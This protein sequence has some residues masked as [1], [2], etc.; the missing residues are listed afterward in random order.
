M[1]DGCYS[2]L[3]YKFVCI[4]QEADLAVASLTINV[5]R[6]KVVDFT[7]PYIEL[8]TLILLY[9]EPE[10]GFSLTRFAEPFSFDLLVVFVCSWPIVGLVAWIAA[11]YS[12]YDRSA[13]KKEKKV[14]A[15]YGFSYSMWAQYGSLTLQGLIDYSI[16]L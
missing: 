10:K 15:L 9:K 6:I 13:L 14:D 5:D 8:G 1:H 3:I 12:P 4:L 11:R 16:L 7:K 2:L